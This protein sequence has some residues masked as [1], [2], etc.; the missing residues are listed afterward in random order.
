MRRNFYYIALFFL[1]SLTV[2]CGYS[3]KSSLPPHFR[4]IYIENFKNNVM[5]TTE[6]QRE[7]YLPLLEVKVRNAIINRFLFD[8][9]LKVVKSEDAD[10]IL[11]GELKKY[12]RSGLRFTDNNDVQEYRVTVTVSFEL[13]EPQKPEP[14]WTESNFS[15]EASFFLSGPSAKSED[16][17]V[18][19]AIDDLARRVVERTVEDW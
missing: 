1:S 8:G 2:G 7:L 5:Y 9:A 11:K 15:G 16:A 12:E 6:T 3:T 18:Q 17:A 19:E 13:R 14:L 4:T 10:L